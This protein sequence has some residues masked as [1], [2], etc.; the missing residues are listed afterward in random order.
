MTQ[1]PSGLLSTR[2][3]CPEAKSSP[4]SAIALSAARPMVAGTGPAS[5]ERPCASARLRATTR[6]AAGRRRRAAG[7]GRLG[8]SEHEAL[9]RI[10]AQ[11]PLR[12]AHDAPD[13]E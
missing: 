11:A 5:K 6:R 7:P 2:A 3:W 10:D 1:T 13:E 8:R 12:G 9:L 4:L